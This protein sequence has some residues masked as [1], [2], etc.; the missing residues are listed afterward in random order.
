[1]VASVVEVVSVSATVTPLSSPQAEPWQRAAVNAR[2]LTLRYSI[3]AS[4]G[5]RRLDWR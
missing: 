2:I 3:E 1:V 5:D 4:Y